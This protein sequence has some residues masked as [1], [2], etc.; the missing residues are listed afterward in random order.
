MWVHLP[1]SEKKAIFMVTLMLVFPRPA[2]IIDQCAMV[3]RS[4]IDCNLRS[5]KYMIGAELGRPILTH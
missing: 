1:Q 5:P 4:K 2:L 3:D